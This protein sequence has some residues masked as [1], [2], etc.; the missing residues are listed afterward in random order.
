M[1]HWDSTHQLAK[2]SKYY[3]NT[4]IHTL[5][6]YIHTYIQLYQVIFVQFKETE[7]FKKQNILIDGVQSLPSLRLM[8]TSDTMNHSY[9]LLLE[10]QLKSMKNI[11]E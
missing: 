8:P 5:T 11:L 3:V 10:H 2:Y 1:F 9:Q 6:L 7:N 4:Y